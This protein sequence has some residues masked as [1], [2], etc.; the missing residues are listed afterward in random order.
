V[1]VIGEVVYTMLDEKV[2]GQCFVELLNVVN[3]RGGA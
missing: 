1:I 3:A 2:S